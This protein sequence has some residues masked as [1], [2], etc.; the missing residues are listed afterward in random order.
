ML[1]I[2]HGTEWGLRRPDIYPTSQD[3]WRFSECLALSAIAF[4]MG[5]EIGHVLRKHSSYTGSARDNH[6]MEFEADRTGL[7]IAVRYALL[8]AAT[9]EESDS[10]YLKFMLY[11]PL[12]AVGVISLFGD[13]D[14][15]T[16]CLS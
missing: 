8:K 12:L 1:S 10:Y 2:W 13:A 6:R 5:H 15:E 3:G 14:S 7:S 16:L 9:M 11:G 4:V